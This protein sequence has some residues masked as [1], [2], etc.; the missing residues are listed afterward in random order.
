MSVVFSD[1]KE[2]ENEDLKVIVNGDTK[3]KSWLV[4]YV[5]DKCDPSD[6]QVTLEM[7]V[8]TV[9]QE[10]PEFLFAVA[11][12]NFVRGYNQAMSDSDL[13]DEHNQC[14]NE[15]NLP[16]LTDPYTEYPTEED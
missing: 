10:F 2:N 16:T 1:D 8:D 6:D 5:G 13:V 7:I 11:E 15:S 14:D 4:D 3:L 9:A 12:E